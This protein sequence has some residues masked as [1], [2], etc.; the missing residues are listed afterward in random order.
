MKKYFSPFFVLF[1]LLTTYSQAELLGFDLKFANGYR[2][3]ALSSRLELTNSPDISVIQDHLK[4]NSISLYQIGL[5]AHLCFL[6]FFVDLEGDYAWAGSGGWKEIDYR[7]FHQQ[8]RLK[9]NHLAGMAKDATLAIGYQF[10]LIPCY[11]ILSIG[12]MIG[13]SYHEQHF[14]TSSIKIPLS[15][16]SKRGHFVYSNQWEGPWAGAKLKGNFGEYSIHVGYEYHWGDWHAKKN[17][18][19]L[20]SLKEY[21]S[22]KG[23]SKNTHGQVFS[24]NTAWHFNLCWHLGFGFKLQEWKA[25]KGKIKSLNEEDLH[26]KLHRTSWSSFAAT[27]EIGFGV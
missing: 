8:T 18:H 17:L 27:L 22:R 3:D 23:R 24:F 12:P 1:I 25:V 21:F 9:S 15:D 4:L 11:Q 2:S 7:N 13:W 16:F 6:N 14:K 26:E 19:G 20:Q 10:N 5:Q